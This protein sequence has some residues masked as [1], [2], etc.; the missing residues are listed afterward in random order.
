MAKL[1]FV[2]LYLINAMNAFVA[3]SGRQFKNI[4]SCGS[5]S[6]QH[7]RLACCGFST[8]TN[9]KSAFS[10]DSDITGTGLQNRAFKT[11][12]QENVR[13]AMNCATTNALFLKLTPMGFMPQPNLRTIPIL[14]P[15]LSP[16]Q[17]LPQ[18]IGNQTHLPLRQHFLFRYQVG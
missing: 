9:A 17:F 12:P 2:L 14:L 10:A 16:L 7:A 18:S 5:E 3:F 4:S 1:G 6:T 8:Q 15:L 13:G 11:L